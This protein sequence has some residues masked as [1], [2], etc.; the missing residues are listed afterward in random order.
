MLL[1]PLEHLPA[2]ASPPPSAK[3]GA[4]KGLKLPDGAVVTRVTASNPLTT[5]EGYVPLTPIQLRV[6]YQRLEG[7]DVLKAEDEVWESETLVTD[8]THRLFVKAQ[9]ICAKGSNLVAV[10]APEAQAGAVPAPAGSPTA[11]AP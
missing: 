2:C 5:I 10:V 3:T 6:Y 7:L 11:P 1:Q 4:I 9:A 8:G